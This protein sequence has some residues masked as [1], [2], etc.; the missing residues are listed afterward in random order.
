MWKEW[1]HFCSVERSRF[2]DPSAFLS[3]ISNREAGEWRC[4]RASLVMV[5]AQRLLAKKG[6]TVS[7]NTLKIRPSV[8]V[9]EGSLIHCF[10]LLKEAP[11]DGGG[12]GGGGQTER[13]TVPVQYSLSVLSTGLYVSELRHVPHCLKGIWNQEGSWFGWHRKESTKH[14]CGWLWWR[15]QRGERKE[16]K[17]TWK[18]KGGWGHRGQRYGGDNSGVAGCILECFHK[19]SIEHTVIKV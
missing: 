14:L 8:V 6:H 3:E 9:S 11:P 2:N 12:E 15:K 4:Y 19:T 7:G 17:E 13:Q 16:R 10:C 1:W 18:R 5:I